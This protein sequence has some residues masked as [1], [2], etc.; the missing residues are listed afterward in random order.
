MALPRV[1]SGPADAKDQVV[2]DFAATG[3]AR[4]RAVF[5]DRDGV[6]TI[7]EFRDGRSFAPTRLADFRIYEDAAA[8]VDALKKAGYV[9]IVVTNQPDVGTGLEIGRAHV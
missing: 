6:L 9:V 4:K 2:E 3:P 5:L 7:P 8:A 1:A